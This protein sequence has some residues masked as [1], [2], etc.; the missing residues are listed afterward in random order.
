[1][2]V[3]FLF[4]YYEQEGDHSP[5]TGGVGSELLTNAESVTI[6]HIPMDSTGKL[7]VANSI[8]FYTSAS[9]DRIDSRISSASKND[10]HWQVDLKYEKEKPGKDRSVQLSAS[11]STESD[12]L[13]SSL[14]LGWNKWSKN[15]NNYYSVGLKA[16]LDTWILIFPQELRSNALAD[17]PTDKR[18][19]FILD[20]SYT[21]VF[22]KRLQGSFFIEPVY[23]MGM[24]ATPFHRVYF[25]NATLPKIER[26]PTSRL[27]FPMGFRLNTFIANFLI[28]RLYSRFYWDDFGITAS[29]FSVEPVFKISNS[30]SAYPFYRYHTQTAATY[31]APYQSHLISE[32]YYTSDYDLSAIN[33]HKLGLGIQFSPVWIKKTEAGATKRRALRSIGIRY[34]QYYR[35]DGL[36]FW[37]ISSAFSF[38]F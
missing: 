29:T 4:N 17:A 3:D 8:N 16:Y 18:R 11:A 15:K 20:L 10:I 2:D 23:Q 25:S 35:S 34:S 33:S 5:V 31:F 36:T 38:S 28:L 37:M 22:T 19:S 32:E 26:L 24:L 1:M 21:R 6:V 9:T 14:G 30:F 12:Y 13:S 27:K 7:N